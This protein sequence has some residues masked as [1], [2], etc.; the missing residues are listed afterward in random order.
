MEEASEFVSRLTG[1]DAAKSL[2]MFTSCCPA[3][4]NLIEKTYPELLPHLSTCKS[5]QG[6]M[7]TLIR[8][9]FADKLNVR[10]DE[11]IVVSMMPCVAKK[12]EIA[13]PQLTRDIINEWGAKATIKETD[14]VL[15]TRELGRLLKRERIP[16]QSIEEAEF[17]TPLGISTGA[18]ALFGAT[19]G[20]MEAALRTAHHMVTGK[21]LKKK[22]V[23]MKDV[24]ALASGHH[25]LKEA[26]VKVGKAELNVAVATGTRN[27]RKLVEQVID[28]TSPYHLIEVMACPGGCVSGGGE[29]KT[30][31]TDPQAVKK[32]IEAIRGIDGASKVRMSHHNE[33]VKEL[34]RDFLHHPQSHKSHELLHTY[35]TDRSGEVKTSHEEPWSDMHRRRRT[36][37]ELH[38]NEKLDFPWNHPAPR[39]LEPMTSP[40]EEKD[41][42]EKQ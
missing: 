7:S 2:P 13:R 24:R 3:W 12:D 15:T 4:I 5:P 11:I 33:G 34:Y 40:A 17:D 23:V 10:P 28:G 9:Y 32:R 20:V 29:P 22:D 35:Y 26:T 41:V 21:D 42:A 31:A 6:M 16:Y 25:N 30:T 38:P 27:I 1:G 8:T 37:D 18:A 19:G 14:Y 36:E 39:E